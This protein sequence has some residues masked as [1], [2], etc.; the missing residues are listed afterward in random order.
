MKAKQTI[1]LL[2]FLLAA[3]LLGW[4]IAAGMHPFTTTKQMVP[5]TDPLFGT[6]TQTWVDKFTPGLEL[7]GPIAAVFGIIGFFLLR[8]GRKKRTAGTPNV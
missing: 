4:W 6:V 1:A 2:L 7:I 3:G 8:S 5:V